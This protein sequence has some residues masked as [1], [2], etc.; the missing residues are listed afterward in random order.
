MRNARKNTGLEISS[1]LES[2]HVVPRSS[3]RLKPVKLRVVESGATP[4]IMVEALNLKKGRWLGYIFAFKTFPIQVLLK[5][6]LLGTLIGGRTLK[7]TTTHMTNI[8]NLQLRSRTTLST[9]HLGIRLLP[10]VTFIISIV[11]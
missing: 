6:P 3:E 1:Q 4:P 5:Q 10:A 11:L 9:G 7:G 8:V 2:H